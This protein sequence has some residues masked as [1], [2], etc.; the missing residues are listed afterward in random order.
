[1]GDYDWTPNKNQSVLSR[2]NFWTEPAAVDPKPALP[3][4]KPK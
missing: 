1:M 2:G 4:T 3:I